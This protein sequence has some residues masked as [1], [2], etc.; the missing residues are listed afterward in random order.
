MKEWYTAQELT[1]FDGL[2]STKQGNIKK[3]QAEQWQSRPRA[4]RGGGFEYHISSLPAPAQKAIRISEGKRAA[5]AVKRSLS[6][7]E[8]AAKA[9]QQ[10]SAK[11]ESLSLYQRL[12][13]HQKTKVDA[14]VVLLGELDV[15][16]KAS[17]LSNKAAYT[18]FSTL[19]NDRQ[20]KV[21]ADIYAGAP[22][23]S[24]ASI[25]RWL[26]IK[27]EKGIAHLCE[28]QGAAR[29]GKG[30]IDSQ[31]ALKDYILGMMTAYPH[32]KASVLDDACRAEFS[33][34]SITLPSE[35]R[36]S[37]WMRNW[38]ESNKA[39]FTAVT[40]PDQYKNKY[41]AAMGSM[42]E[43]VVS[44]NQL[45]EFDST[46][47][48][49]MLTDGRHSLLGVIDVYS[50]RA[51]F[52]VMPTSASKGVAQVIRQALLT[53]GVPEIAKTD[54]GADYKSKW[55]RH[56]FESL[57][58]EQRFCKPFHGWEKP[59]IE[60]VFRTFSH[61]NAE[62]L[63]GFIGH[64]VADR[65]DIESRKAF[66][67]RIFEKDQVI[68][69]SM[70]SAE[71]QQ[72]CNEWIQNKYHTSTHS[73]LGCSPNAKAAQYNGSISTINNPRL[74]D[75]L[76]SEKAG[77]R[78]IGKE[79]IK[80]FGGEYIHAEL[81][82]HIG[83]TVNVFY[84]DTDIGNIYVYDLD[85]NF[86]CEAQ[87][88]TTTG[89]SREEVAAKAKQ[90]QKESIQEERRRLKAESKKVTSRDVAQQILD[91]RAAE[92]REQKVRH[93]PRPEV[94]HTSDGLTAAADAL[95][96]K[97]QN[98]LP[99][100]FDPEKPAPGTNTPAPKGKAAV[101]QLDVKRGLT[102]PQNPFEAYQYWQE[103]QAKV[104][105]GTA[106]EEETNWVRSFAQTPEW[107]SGKM[108]TEMREKTPAATGGTQ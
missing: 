78:V 99:H 44:L 83:E 7:S 104:I 67:D 108:L 10:Q 28:D 40:S 46:P 53:W 102:V 4:G 106:T 92:E 84:D 85:G 76:L 18:E 51:L 3:A 33:G 8:L 12:K 98:N 45:W 63:P 52:V 87:D 13:P 58:I 75:V 90:I 41:M 23:C 81:A 74:L 54:N 16:V 47:A 71:L 48:D 70:S 1:A 86:I 32:I 97:N 68:D 79:G 73:E 2:P 91:H 38:K 31:P 26:K 9:A 15:F 103:T 24:R 100:W 69:V 35:R 36:L 30:T 72:F 89:V 56:V 17:G 101:V 77:T 95:A 66:S 64:N 22:K 80:L 42:S 21:D 60:R 94:E 37:E 34:K 105:G 43:S 29:R 61:D 27:N 5:N 59:H 93:M 62:L 20:I 57:D 25:Y 55:I 11:A 49:L 88:P 96:A 6:A 39:L 19:W 65:K 107:R 82:A 14:I 50:R